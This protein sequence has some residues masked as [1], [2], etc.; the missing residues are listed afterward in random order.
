MDVRSGQRRR[1]AGCLIPLLLLAITMSSGGASP[2]VRVRALGI[3]AAARDG[4]LGG[5]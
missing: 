3:H 2:D 1:L 4:R 5:S